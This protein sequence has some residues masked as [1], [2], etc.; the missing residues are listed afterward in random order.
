MAAAAGVE[1][2]ALFI[3]EAVASVGGLVIAGALGI[4]VSFGAL[5]L[6]NVIWKKYWLVL[7]IYNFD[8]DYN[9]SNINHHDDNAN[10]SNGEWK[11]KVVEKFVNAGGAVA[12]PGFNPVEPLDN[13]VTYLSMTFENDSTIL[14]G[15]G[16]G[17][18]M[19]REDNKAGM[20]LKYVVHRFKDNEI[21]LKGIEGDPS[22]FDIAGYYNE[23]NWVQAKSVEIQS[24][25]YK[26]T[27]YTAALSGDK[28]GVYT[29]EVN[30][31]LPPP[32]T[33][34]S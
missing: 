1:S 9:W 23:D 10:V 12:P 25:S 8:A 18:L 11:T 30:L 3:P 20:A 19:A 17:V 29:Y 13:V 4:L 15:L 5:A 2:L 33:S 34:R 14:Q 31:G 28:E 32:V 21:G 22:K 24:G 7:N 26:M 16:E 27:G 6:M